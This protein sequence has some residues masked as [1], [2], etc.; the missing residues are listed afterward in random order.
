MAPP[1]QLRYALEK[2]NETLS[3]EPPKQEEEEE[4][5]AEQKDDEPSAEY[6]AE[7]ARRAPLLKCYKGYMYRFIITF[8]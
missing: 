6:K 1:E 8:V 4:A 3:A 5:P 7:G 2:V